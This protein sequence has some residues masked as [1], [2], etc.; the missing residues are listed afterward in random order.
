M[1]LRWVNTLRRRMPLGWKQLK[2][3]R[4]RLLAAIAGI[5]FA[6]ILI[7]MQLGFQDALYK[8]NTQYP[9]RLNADVV[10]LSAQ[11]NNLN[12]LFTFP[13]RRLYQ[14][15]DV[16]GVVA[17]DPLYVGSVKWRNPQ[18]REKTSILA[19]GFNPDRPAFDLP[20]ANAQLDVIKLPDTVLFDRAS[21][22][23]YQ[24]T[25][26]TV[27][28]GSSAPIEVDRHTIRV[29]GLFALGA[30]FNDDGA[31]MGSEQTFLRLFPRRSAGAVS[32]GT[33]QVDPGYDV[34]TVAAALNDYLPD[35]VVAMTDAEYVAFELNYIQTRSAIGFVFGLGTMMGFV[36]GVV[37]VYQVL[38]TDVNAHLAEYATFKAMGYRQR[39]LLG[40][41]LE[42]ALLLSAIG[43]VPSV[44]IAL[45]LYTLTQ[46]ATA[47][48]IA[49]PIGRV[50][51]VFV[52]TVIMCSVSGGIAT[53]RLQ[54][55]DPADIF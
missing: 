36:V 29:E 32:L 37:I 48:P 49:M 4:T 23:D 54:S 35:D 9:R 22:G 42:E 52:L 1:V 16:P 46:A 55:A 27:E 40:V 7:F 43:F 11:A 13:R 45:G 47:L 38:S 19:L 26:A 33:L 25:I 6:D 44:G 20:E 14:A 24:E 31:V 15:L 8:A 51:V 53:R 50:V 18:T 28:A 12:Q 5:A 17:A 21:R 3:D 39:Y 41:V 2:H 10:L 34:A 30:S